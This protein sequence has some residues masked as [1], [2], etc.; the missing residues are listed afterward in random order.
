MAANNATLAAG[1]SADKEKEMSFNNKEA[2]QYQSLSGFLLPL[3]PI[4]KR[5]R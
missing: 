3:H 4:K 2:R 5:L 1:A